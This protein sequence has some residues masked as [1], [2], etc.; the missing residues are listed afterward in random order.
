MMAMD[1]TVLATN[2]QMKAEAINRMKLLGLKEEYIDAFADDKAC[3]ITTFWSK[4][5]KGF[6]PYCIEDEE[7]KAIVEFE[8][9]NP[10]LAWAVIHDITN[11]EGEDWDG[12]YILFV[13]E[14][15]QKWEDE[16]KALLAGT[17]VVYYKTVSSESNTVRTGLDTIKIEIQDGILFGEM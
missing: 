12:Y 11:E 4:W 14:D 15:T 17:P 16:R 3:E 1:N 7:E 13:S 2:E 9:S 6:A 5:V 8:K 10:G